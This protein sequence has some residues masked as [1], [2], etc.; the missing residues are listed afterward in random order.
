[1]KCFWDRKIEFVGVVQEVSKIINDS[2]KPAFQKYGAYFFFN[3]ILRRDI[4]NNK[5][6]FE[7]LDSHFGNLNIKRKGEKGSPDCVVNCVAYKNI[8]T[9]PFQK[10][11]LLQRESL[12]A[13]EVN[14][15]EF[16]FGRNDING[17]HRF[18]VYDFKV[19]DENHLFKMKEKKQ[20]ELFENGILRRRI[21]NLE[22]NNFFEP[23]RILNRQVALVTSFYDFSQAYQDV[24]KELAKVGIKPE[25]FEVQ[26]KH[27][28]DVVNYLIGELHRADDSQKFDFII[29]C[30]G[31]GNFSDLSLF[32]DERLAYCLSELKTPV[33]TGIGHADNISIADLAATYCASTPSTAAMRLRNFYLLQPLMKRFHQICS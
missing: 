1:M 13:L 19:L 28:G 17:A 22:E 12:I 8:A 10:R 33:I 9:E 15:M 29:L 24:E 2:T 21:D 30:R 27:Q 14:L 32:D 31:G 11:D 6:F 5:G 25:R 4:A 3:V 23:N 18:L 16:E 7:C 20:D 26:W